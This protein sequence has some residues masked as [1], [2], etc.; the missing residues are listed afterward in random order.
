MKN[1]RDINRSQVWGGF[2]KV[3][4]Y[5]GKPFRRVGSYRKAQRNAKSQQPRSVAGL[6]VN[7]GAAVIDQIAGSHGQ[8]GKDWNTTA[9]GWRQPRGDDESVQGERQGVSPLVKKKRWWVG[10]VALII[11]IASA[12][13][14]AGED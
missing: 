1:G 10:G 11:I 9:A 7:R 5:D 3:Y 12:A 14:G 2:S 6:L 8:S 13:G 4:V